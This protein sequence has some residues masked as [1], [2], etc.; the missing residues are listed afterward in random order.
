MLRPEPEGPQGV[1]GSVGMNGVAVRLPG[2][3]A[4]AGE[5][6]ASAAATLICPNSVIDEAQG[7][8]VPGR[9]EV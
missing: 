7:G 3:A 2:S 8:R 6:P 1:S 9:K 4:A 5:V